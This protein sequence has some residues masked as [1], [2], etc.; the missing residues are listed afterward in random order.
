[1]RLDKFLS[2]CDV[3]TRSQVKKYIK[4]GSVTCNG[5]PVSDGKLQVDE[6]AD[7]ICCQGRQ[8]RYEPF[9][10]YLFHKPKGCVCAKKDRKHDTVFSY[11]PMNAKNDLFPVG[12]LDLD[13][14]GLLI[15]TNDGM[16]SHSLLS[17]R[18]HV[19]KIYF[20]ELNQP[21]VKTDIEA[22]AK[23]LDI[24]DDSL[25]KP[26]VLTIEE[27]NPCQVR[28]T[29]SEGRYHQVKRMVHAVGKK[30]LYLKRI[31]MGKYTL[32]DTLA[33][34]E[35]RTFTERELTY[36]EEYKSGIV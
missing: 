1:M 9:V 20:A 34:G 33:P 27:T 6:K 16:F 28:I 13:T 35:Y 10:Y 26:A 32:E 5:I 17:P 11:V 19:D 14:E 24:G 12:R 29:I 18:K 36:V 2:E 4:Q 30:V 3:G 15:I 8:L 7:L 31:A 21:A 22:F 23:G 25:T